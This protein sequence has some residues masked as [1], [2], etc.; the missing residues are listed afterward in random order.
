[1]RRFCFFLLLHEAI[2]V[3]L[4]VFRVSAQQVVWER[5]WGFVA[6]GDEISKIIQIDDG[7]FLAIGITNKYWHQV[8]FDF[9]SSPVLIKLDSN[10]DTLFLK[11]FP[12]P[13]ARIAY[14][15]HKFGNVYQ[16]VIQSPINDNNLPV[17]YPCILEFTDEGE[18]L[19]TKYL[20]SLPEYRPNTCIKT[21]DGGL[22]LAG[23][24]N[25][26]LSAPTNMMAI[27]VNFLNE[28]EW[29]YQYLP[30]VQNA[31]Y[32]NRLEKMANG[33]YLLSGPLG[34]RI[35]GYEIDSN[36]VQVGQK[37]FYETPSNRVFRNGEAAQGF[38]K[39]SFSYGYYLDGSNNTVGYFGK[40]D[41]LGN[42]VWG[43]EL[44]INNVN[45]LVI[46]RESSFLVSRNGFQTSIARLTKDS[47]ELWK[48]ILGTGLPYKF[49]NGLC[50]AQPDTGIVYGYYR[51]QGGNLG[52]QF[53]L[54]KI[55]GVGTAYDPSNPGDTVTVSTQEKLFRPKDAPVLYPN[56]V[57]ESFQFSKLTEESMLTIYST[58]G[59]KL[60]EKPIMPG[61]KINAFNLPKGIYLYHIRMGKRVLTGKMIKE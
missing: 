33:N 18:L 3:W 26:A 50:F 51:Q 27:K 25:G 6:Y 23:Y 22:I 30:P 15:G 14:L 49:V 47:I 60:F 13:V 10:G 8:G 42:K 19:S 56:P 36:S 12:V 1:M 55:A 43:G 45:N 39:G 9:F 61:E 17:G 31:G 48:V 44:P 35:Y 57:C 2:A 11:P 53:W 40:Q 21:G 4:P 32:G 20:T 52:N 54:A 24:Y 46:N 34:R 38:W 58:K 5:V 16:A 59:E 37:T 41:S 7:Q 29:S 28:V